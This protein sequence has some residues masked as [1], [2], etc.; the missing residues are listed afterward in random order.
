MRFAVMNST[1]VIEAAIGTAKN[2]L[3]QNELVHSPSIQS[4]LQRSS[5]SFLAFALREV[6]FVAADES[7]TDQQIIARLWDVL[8]DPHLNQALGTPQNSRMTLVFPRLGRIARSA[9]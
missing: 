3:W 5:D 1:R 9:S 6:E 4:A 7:R 8:D 2:L